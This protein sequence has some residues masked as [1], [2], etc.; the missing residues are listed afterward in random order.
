M[1]RSE[2][3]QVY[4][5]LEITAIAS[6]GMGIARHEGLVIF[7]EQT[8]TGDIV[9]VRITRKKSG[10]RQGKPVF[11]HRYSPIR[12][13][14]VCDHFGICGGCKWQIISYADQLEHKVRQV[15]DALHRIGKI[16]LPEIRPMIGAPEPYFY[17]NKLEYTF[18]DSGWLTDEEIRS[19][20]DFAD[21]NALGF[22][23]PGRFDKVLDIH[24]CYLQPD[25]GNAIRNFIKQYA[26]KHQLTFFNLI[27]QTGF[28][29]T[30][31]LRN[32][33]A[34]EWMV[35][36]SVTE[37]QD[38]LFLLLD[39]LQAQFPEI[40]SLLYAINTKR[41]DTLEALEVITYKGLPY[42]TEE[43]EGIKF[44]IGPKS[45]YQTNPVQAYELYKVARDFAG[46]SA[47]DTV[48]DL[49]TGA[50]TIALFVAGMA[51]K[52]IG[53]EY[54]EDA[55]NDAKL[56][57]QLN[58]IQNTSFF[59]GDMKNILVE[60]FFETHGK[61]DVII[62]DPPRAGMHEDV[63][64]R[65]AESGASR[66]VY[67]SCN[68]ATQARDLNL[69]DANYRVV[70]IQPVDMFPQTTHVENVVLLEKRKMPQEF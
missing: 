23:I 45:F 3:V 14:P 39:A 50:G 13:K 40:T 63:C 25:P 49:Y 10:F 22:H 69:L 59:S 20:K 24:K 57:A 47:T 4:E 55:V 28:L 61:P 58:R 66:I 32:T 68:P 33:R 37:K 38:A 53:I 44:N 29:R 27:K 46:I 12:I 1:G 2:K 54:V 8:V 64:K 35:C 7:V 6:E 51:K 17:R 11:F 36:L 18:S 31:I 30:L 5:K 43:M 34:G 48:Y 16:E 62:T 9:D 70:S 65:I 42:I 26:V 56:N 15:H 67:V 52:V 60:G 41:N 19:G 21:R